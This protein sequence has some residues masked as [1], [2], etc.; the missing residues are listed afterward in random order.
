MVNRKSGQLDY[1]D[2]GI[3][4]TAKWSVIR[5]LFSLELNLRSRKLSDL[6]ETAVFPQP[7]ERQ[8]VSTC[9]RVFSEKTYVA[10]LT[11]PAISQEDVNDT[12]IFIKKVVEW[13]K[14]INVRALFAD[15]KHNEP[16]SAEIRNLDD[17]RLVSLLQFGNMALN[18]KCDKKVR[19]R[20]LT[21]D[22]A[23]AIHHTCHG[24]VAFCK[25]LR[26]TTHS[27]VVLGQFT[28]D[29]L[30]RVWHFATGFWWDLLFVRATDSRKGEN[31]KNRF[32]VEA[33]GI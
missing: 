18:M 6:N 10:L 22:T 11:H 17:P 13:W 26:A 4:G 24:I 29:H 8:R 1:D 5:K 28:S 30:E 16:L 7:I 14:I 3:T 27:Y 20:Q 19:T 32:A 23:I 33:W 9:L 2:C 21:K 31:S 12:A 25:H 15:T